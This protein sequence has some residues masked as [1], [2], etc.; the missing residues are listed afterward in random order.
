MVST[1]ELIAYR[2][3]L[4]SEARERF[5][6]NTLIFQK[7]LLRDTQREET[8]RTTLLPILPAPI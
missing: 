1:N 2:D 3:T 8:L 5:D 7:Q 6:A 4:S